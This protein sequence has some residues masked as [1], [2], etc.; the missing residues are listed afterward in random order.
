MQRPHR[1]PVAL[2]LHASNYSARS[3][4]KVTPMDYITEA[5][6]PPMGSTNRR[7]PIAGQKRGQDLSLLLLLL[8]CLVPQCWQVLLPL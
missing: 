1:G 3:M 6:C 7:H 4:E 2:L 5:S 8:L